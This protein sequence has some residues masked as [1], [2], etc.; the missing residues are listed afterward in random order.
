MDRSID[1]RRLLGG[2]AAGVAA[3][4]ATRFDAFADDATPAASPVVD[5]TPDAGATPVAPPAGPPNILVLTVDQ[6]RAPAGLFTQEIMDQVAPNLATLRQKGVEFTNQYIAAAM[7][8]PSRACF[9]TGLYTH[10][11]GMLLTNT[12][13]LT[14]V[15]DLT[16]PSLDERF[17]TYGHLLSE[18]GYDTPWFGKWHISSDDHRTGYTLERY[19]FSHNEPTP[20]ANGGPGQGMMRDDDIAALFT[21]YVKQEHDKPWCATVAL[22]NPH[23]IAFYP[24]ATEQIPNQ[25]ESPSIFTQLPPNWE[26]PIESLKQGKPS[27]QR[28]MMLSAMTLFGPMPYFPEDKPIPEGLPED[29]PDERIPGFP[30]VWY[31]FQDLYAKL[32]GMVDQQIGRVLKALADSPYANNTIIVFTSDHGEY[33]GAHGLRG[34]GVGLYDESIRVPLYILDPTGRFQREVGAI[35]DQFTSSVDI[36]PFILT[37][38]TGGNEWRSDPRLAY[39]AN[40]LDLGAVI[41]DAAHPGREY[42]VT[43]CDEEVI[44]TG[45]RLGSMGAAWFSKAVPQ[46]AIGVRTA[47]AMVGV[48]S[49]FEPGTITPDTTRQQVE[50]YDYTTERGRLELDNVAHTNPNPAMHNTA[51]EEQMI[52]RWKLAIAEELQAP[53]PESL[54]EVQ[55]KAFVDYHTYV[56]AFADAVGDING[57]S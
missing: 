52:A 51:L 38:A 20:A 33:I 46:H 12:E 53:L 27:V 13:G 15:G 11:N 44:E 19:G 57:Q 4:G 14:G 37:A 23:D 42:I 35:R 24:V 21:D 36:M 34:K 49:F 10:Q 5:A 55:A 18:L 28:Q 1:R 6:L 7:C 29:F 48:Y 40:R 30:Q 45:Q 39:L 16:S 2:A 43:T 25:D 54:V 22:I 41:Q 31:E 8:S 3:V 32:T 56:Q 9:I 26:D 17:P 47:D 50:L